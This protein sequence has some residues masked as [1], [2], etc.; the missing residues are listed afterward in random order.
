MVLPL[1]TGPIFPELPV[2]VGRVLIGGTL[3]AMLGGPPEPTPPSLPVEAP[4]TVTRIQA[5]SYLTQYY[6]EG[7]SGSGALSALK[8]AG[9]GYRKQDFYNDWRTTVGY[10]K[11]KSAVMNL[12]DTDLVP[13]SLQSAGSPGQTSTFSYR[14]TTP[15]GDPARGEY[16]IQH[17]AVNSEH[18]LTVGQATAQAQA[19]LDANPDRYL[20][21]IG[22]ATLVGVKVSQ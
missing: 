9:L 8:E 10:E 4:W 14:F 6:T 20:G 7:M 18:M 2:L 17:T 22:R 19:D 12:K 1:P 16:G 13:E 11:D 21:Q 3:Q 5:N 15:G